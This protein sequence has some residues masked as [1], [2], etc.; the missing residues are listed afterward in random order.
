MQFFRKEVKG[1]KCVFM[2]NE[3]VI[4]GV[5]P[6]IGA[7]IVSIFYKP[8]NFEVLFQ[9]PLPRYKHPPHG[10]SFADYDT[11][12]ADEMFPTI[13]PCRYPFE[14]YAGTPCPDHG[15]L[16]SV[17]WNVTLTDETIVCEVKTESI[18][19]EFHREISLSENTLRFDYCVKNTGFYP[20]YGLWA[21]HGLVQCDEET[22]IELPDVRSV[23]VVHDSKTYGKAGTVIPFPV[24]SPIPGRKI[25]V[26]QVLPAA[27]KS[28]EKFYVNGKAPKGEASLLLNKRS[29]RYTLRFPYIKIPYVGVWIDQGGFKN[30][31]NIALEPSNGFYD[32]LENVKMLNSL[33][34]IA[35]G[36][37]RQW[38]LEIEL[39]SVGKG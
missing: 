31:Y 12:G 9:T 25:R 8:Q 19:C 37:S 35:P 13:D 29:L 27:A 22:V 5:L 2:E 4:A 36:Q 21:F 39:S 6:A 30:E 24:F 1:E 17:P 14:G 32:S 3:T 10:D 18:P 23:L 16:W 26:D 28:T 38:W 15:D 34:P 7:K 33:T 20:L 11:S